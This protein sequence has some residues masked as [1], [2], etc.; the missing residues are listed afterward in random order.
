[1]KRKTA[2]SSG[3]VGTSGERQCYA[4]APYADSIFRD[5]LGDREGSIM[6]LKRALEA[7]PT[8]APAILSMGSILFQLGR[9]AEGRQ[10][11]QSLLSLPKEHNGYLPDHR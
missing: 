6:A 5:A 2:E 1:M 4:E 9:I 10:L 3:L 8:Y 11:F 7:M